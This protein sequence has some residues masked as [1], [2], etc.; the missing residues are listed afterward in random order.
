TAVYLFSAYVLG[1]FPRYIG[2]ILLLIYVLYM[3]V[4]LRNALKQAKEGTALPEEPA[5]QPQEVPEGS[6]ESSEQEGEEKPKKEK[7]TKLW[8]EIVMLVVGAALIAVGA[9]LLVDNGTEIAKMLGVPEAVIAL[10]FVAL[11]T[12]LPEL[13]TAIT[14]LVKGHGSL[15]LGNVIGANLFNLVLVSGLASAIMPFG[16]PAGQ[17]LFGM[18][19]SLVIDVPLMVFVMA[20]LTLPA[21]I[22]Q[23]LY[24]VQG[25]LL[26]ALYVGFIVSQFWLGA[27]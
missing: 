2:I 13:V 9:D 1:G 26:L 18:P 21:L 5:E 7:Q 12:S 23:K 11:G 16:L 27:V 19:S 8:L 17:T 22:K 6:G 15:S 10:T 24:R 3:T 4:V 25:I 20:F 14:S